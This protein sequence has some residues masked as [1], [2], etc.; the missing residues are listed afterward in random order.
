MGV[1]NLRLP[2][3]D[4]GTGGAWLLSALALFVP[5]YCLI[6]WWFGESRVFKGGRLIRPQFW[7]W[8]WWRGLA[9]RGGGPVGGGV[10]PKDVG[11]A[12]CGGACGL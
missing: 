9:I 6:R 4:T 2:G 7:R 10:G 3:F 1:C 11:G 8:W 5:K 12:G